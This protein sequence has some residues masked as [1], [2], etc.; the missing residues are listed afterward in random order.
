MTP[1]AANKHL[2][3][4]EMAK[5]LEAGFGIR[6]AAEVMRNTRLPAAQLRL[7]ETLNA[8]LEAGETIAG[9]FSRAAG[10]VGKLEKS[11]IAAGERGGKLAPAF[12]HLAGYF[13][14]VAAAR[15]E[16]IKGMIYPIIVLHLGVFVGTVPMA[17]MGGEA[18]AGDIAV[19]FFTA[20]GV[21]Y[22]GALV[23]FFAFRALLKMAPVSP[24]IDRAINRIPWIGKARR[25]MGMSRFCK[26]YHACL[27]AGISMVET[28]RVSAESAQS[29]LLLV[30]G[31]RIAAVAEQ[32]NA[33][34]PQFIAEGAFPKSFSR[35]Y[36]TGEEAGTLDTDMATWARLFQENAHSSMQAAS[37]MIPKILYFFIMG[38]VAWKIVGFFSGYY[39]AL[40]A[41]GD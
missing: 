33:L 37:L 4:T 1:S 13:G 7:L 28:V 29:G 25:D 17:M 35:S 6:K 27:L 18:S 41:I 11:M 22:L 5:L 38:F 39:G 9:A 26:V 32:G 19:G 3:Y 24:G 16:A 21:M 8:G 34:G 12:A 20:L 15:R 10:T 31:K 2:F 40:D 14:M 23:M 36:A 30:A